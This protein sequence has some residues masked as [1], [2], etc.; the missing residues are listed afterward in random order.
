MKN[1]ATPLLAAAL[2]THE[3]CRIKNLPRIRDVERMIEILKMLGCVIKWEDEHTVIINSKNLNSE[4]LQRSSK[5]SEKREEVRSAIRSMRSSVLLMG[6]LLARFG[7]VKLPEPGGCIIGKRPLDAHLAAIAPFGVTIER[8]DGDYFLTA[9]QLA[10]ARVVLPE[11]SVT[12]T[13]NALMV[14]AAINGTSTISLAALEPHVQQLAR[15]LVAMGAQIRGIG[16]HTMTIRGAKKLKGF[17]VTLIPDQI[18]V[19]TF[20]VAAA[21]T[22]GRLDIH[23]VE[24][25]HLDFILMKAKSIGV[26]VE[27]KGNHLLV[28]PSDHLSDFRL[29]TLPYPGFPTDLQSVFGALATQCEGTSLIQDPLFEGRMGYVNELVKMGANAVICDPHRVL[30]TGPTP[31][32]ATEIRSLDLRAGATLLIASLVAS[33]ETVIHDA[34]VIERGYED[35]D[36]RLRLVGADIERVETP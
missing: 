26:E 9:G 16:T 28:N 25:Q 27:L 15:T 14:A 35:I 2:L 5:K 23:P 19:G 31:L 20:M 3:D 32:Y 29:Q 1:A 12:A 21:L 34:Q 7:T 18:E 8:D 24:P 36:G 10:Q 17:S 4:L 33:G 30:V 6:P 13:E 22:R 11:F